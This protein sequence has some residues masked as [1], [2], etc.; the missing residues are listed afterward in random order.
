[1]TTNLVP[2]DL[3]LPIESPI[4]DELFHIEKEYY[5]SN[6][7]KEISL[8]RI[9]RIHNNKTWQNIIDSDGF[10]A[11]PNWEDFCSYVSEGLSVS[12]QLIF[13]RIR[14]YSE[15][16]WL[17]YDDKEI[18]LKLAEKPSFYKRLLDLSMDWNPYSGEPDAILIPGVE[19]LSQDEAKEKLK[20]VLENAEIFNT[21][22]DA[23]THFQTEILHKPKITT[24]I[25][26][27]RLIVSYETYAIGVDGSSI[28]DNYG[29]IQ[30]YPDTFVT[31]EVL[32]YL[33]KITR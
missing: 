14:L 9:V 7:L 29:I 18:I 1:M 31:D 12:R 22:K 8:Y 21:Q 26:N 13:D 6:L 10:Q 20:E 19:D 17:G 5:A 32:D 15:L 2:N 25:D 27:D 28:L 24:K 33:K 3:T 30:F 11:Y 23:I 16:R 4:Q